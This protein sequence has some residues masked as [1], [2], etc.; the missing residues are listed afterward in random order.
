MR[1]PSNS[2]GST[3]Y[4]YGVLRGRILRGE[5]GLGETI[6]TDALV[7]EFNVGSAALSRAVHRLEREGLLET[8]TPGAIRVRLPSRDEVAGHF[9]VREALEVHAAS[10]FGVTASDIDRRDILTLAIE[11]DEL[12]HRRAHAEYLDLHRRLHQRIVESTRYKSLSHA[13]DTTSALVTTWL[14]VAMSVT[15]CTSHR[16]LAEV[17]V[18]GDFSHST[19]AMRGHIQGSHDKVMEA[20]EPY[21]L[22]RAK[23]QAE[24][25][26]RKED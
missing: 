23:E 19:S 14:A 2:A 11:L 1:G 18:L 16:A 9:A 10:L 3:A 21:F 8:H 6:A 25:P 13:L 5:Y 15:M 12:A 17:L 24:P 22:K 20:L 4:S 26:P 7:A